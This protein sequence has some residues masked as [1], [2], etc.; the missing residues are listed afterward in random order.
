MLQSPGVAQGVLLLHYNL[1]NQ[2]P[3]LGRGFM[4]LLTLI[5]SCNDNVIEMYAQIASTPNGL[6][7]MI[8]LRE[9]RQHFWLH[10]RTF[11]PE[12]PSQMSGSPKLLINFQIKKIAT[13]TKPKQINTV[14][15]HTHDNM[16]LRIGDT[17][18]NFKTKT[19]LGD[20]DFHEWAGDK[21]VVFFR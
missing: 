11:S 16:S 8:A 14:Q 1:F 4:Q 6:C 2:T 21:W 13:T 12:F 19:Q 10:P 20:I 3:L 18:P 9:I 15:S 5:A 7:T 17:A